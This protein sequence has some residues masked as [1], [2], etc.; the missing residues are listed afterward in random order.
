VNSRVVRVLM[1]GTVIQF[2]IGLN[3]FAH[4]ERSYQNPKLI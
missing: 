3:I 4:R 2:A 1:L